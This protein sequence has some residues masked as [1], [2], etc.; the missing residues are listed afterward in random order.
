MTP[1]LFANNCTT[2]AAEKGTVPSPPWSPGCIL[3]RARIVQSSLHSLNPCEASDGE[4]CEEQGHGTVWLQP[5]DCLQ[6][7]LAQVPAGSGV[8]LQLSPHTAPHP[9]SPVSQKSFS[10]PLQS[11]AKRRLKA[12]CACQPVCLCNI[13]CH[14]ATGTWAKPQAEWTTY[15]CPCFS[16]LTWP[17]WSS[18]TFCAIFLQYKAFLPF[19]IEER[20]FFSDLG[21]NY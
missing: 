3:R 4:E 2:K 5:S 8:K 11:Q 6:P 16:Q 7:T 21:H 19:F 10:A 13:I 9:T 17:N 15:R 1:L 18:S 14:S 12:P 20:I